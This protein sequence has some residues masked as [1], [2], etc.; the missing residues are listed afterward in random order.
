MQ[1]LMAEEFRLP[2]VAMQSKNREILRATMK[3]LNLLK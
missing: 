1:G 3:K 2:L